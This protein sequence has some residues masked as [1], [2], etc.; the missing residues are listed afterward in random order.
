MFPPPYSGLTGLGWHRH[1]GFWKTLVNLSCRQGRPSVCPVCGYFIV[2]SSA[3][4]SLAGKAA[5]VCPDPAC[6]SGA[7]R[8]QTGNKESLSLICHPEVEP[9]G[10]GWSWTGKGCGNFPVTFPRV[11]SGSLHRTVGHREEMRVWAL[12]FFYCFLTYVH[13]CEPL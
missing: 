2:A 11:A 13:V 12:G 1:W 8:R 7:R 9:M 6:S 3:S 5:S 10:L 4:S